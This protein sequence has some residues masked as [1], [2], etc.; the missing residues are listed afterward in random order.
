MGLAISSTATGP[1]GRKTRRLAEITFTLHG[2]PRRLAA[3]SIAPQEDLEHAAAR[4][5][6]W[7]KEKL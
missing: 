1:E 2:D 6:Q 4:A 7:L 3:V 5:R